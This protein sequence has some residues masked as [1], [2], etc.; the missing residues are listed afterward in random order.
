VR[1]I[2]VDIERSR[3]RVVVKYREDEL[4]LKLN[5]N[6]ARKLAEDLSKAVEDFEQRRH[7]RID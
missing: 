4:V 1:E 3:V 5:V 2:G 7:I 6:E